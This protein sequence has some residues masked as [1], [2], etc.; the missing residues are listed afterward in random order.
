MHQHPLRPSPGELAARDRREERDLLSLRHGVLET[1]PLAVHHHGA[2]PRDAREPIAERVREGLHDVLDGSTG[3]VQLPLPGDVAQRREQPH[4]GHWSPHVWYSIRASRSANVGVNPSSACPNRDASR[5]RLGSS[6]RR[7]SRRPGRDVRNA[8]DSIFRGGG[9]QS[10][11]TLRRKG[12]GYVGSIT[13][14]V[15]R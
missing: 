14:G 5:R 15:R 11:L 3:D 13:M 10:L 12:A 9:L 6:A 7:Y 4:P 1:G 8:Q 2:G